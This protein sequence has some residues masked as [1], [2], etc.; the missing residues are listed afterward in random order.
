MCLHGKCGVQATVKM[1]VHM[2]NVGCR[3]QDVFTW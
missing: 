1:R 2:A 3:L